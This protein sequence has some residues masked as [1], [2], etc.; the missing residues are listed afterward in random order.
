MIVLRIKELAE[1]KGITTAYQLQMLMNIPPTTAARWWKAKMGKIALTTLDALCEALGCDP[2]E[3][4]VRV[5][6]ENPSDAIK[7][8]TGDGKQ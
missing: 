7:K 2:G 4:I 1:R 6:K 3:L 5:S 8:K